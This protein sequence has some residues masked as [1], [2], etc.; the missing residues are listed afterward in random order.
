M[1]PKCGR[2]SWPAAPLGCICA[3]LLSAP[4]AT[5]VAPATPDHSPWESADPEALLVRGVAEFR[6]HEMRAGITDLER[7]ADLAP[8]WGV[9]RLA[10]GVGLLRCGRFDEAAEHFSAVVGPDRAR[11]LAAGDLEAREL[12]ADA[13]DTSLVADAVL[14]LAFAR[15]ELGE[16]READRLYRAY[17]DIV[18]QTSPESA[19]AAARLA[20]L[21]E[22]TGVTWGDAAAERARATALD[23]SIDQWST[24]PEFPD[25]A[26]IP[27]TEPYTRTIEHA[28][29]HLP[30]PA[31]FEILP[32]L[33]SWRSPAGSQSAAARLL[34]KTT[35]VEIL[36]NDDGTVT[37]IRLPEHLDPASGAAAAVIDSVKTWRFAPAVSAGRPVPA[38]IVFEVELP[39]PAANAHDSTR[40]R[41][42]Q[43]ES[44][45]P[46]DAREHD[47]GEGA[48]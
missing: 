19:R 10:L 46:H 12:V 48:P 47:P 33:M 14:G 44:S 37:E 17:S 36:V 39:L 30:P 11:D 5:A 43:S 45:E 3:A 35:D 24:L 22:R 13:A 41:G 32:V 9:A 7:A 34:G 27:E 8:N 28:P 40:L 38:W 6:R 1:A 21:Y 25:L 20:S 4:L 31:G 16:A 26:T 29:G 23:P 42:D 15:D 2:R 18:G